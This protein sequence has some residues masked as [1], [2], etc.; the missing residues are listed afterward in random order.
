MLLAVVIVPEPDIA[1]NA[2]VP[3]FRLSSSLRHSGLLTQLQVIWSNVLCP[4]GLAH[5]QWIPLLFLVPR[6]SR[7][8][9]PPP[10]RHPGLDPGSR[11]L[12]GAEQLTR[13]AAAKSEN[14]P[15][16]SLTSCRT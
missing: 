13:T 2:A 4:K 15:G 8:R 3:G 12:P 10:D 1:G 14:A 11:C 6:A 7:S 9:P 16:P 5:G